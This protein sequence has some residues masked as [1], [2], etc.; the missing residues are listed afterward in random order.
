VSK[1][2]GLDARKSMDES[3][4]LCQVVSPSSRL[5][6]RACVHDEGSPQQR[7]HSVSRLADLQPLL[8]FGCGGENARDRTRWRLVKSNTRREAPNKRAPTLEKVTAWHGAA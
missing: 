6:V 5:P 4:L 3:V 1:V 7:Q 2:P 8:N